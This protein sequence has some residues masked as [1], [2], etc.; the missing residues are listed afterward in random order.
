MRSMQIIGKHWHVG[1]RAQRGENPWGD[2]QLRLEGGAIPR[3]QGK[4]LKKVGAAF[5]VSTQA[6]V[7][8]VS[9]LKC[10]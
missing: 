8:I 10:R 4:N 1:G 3:L 2:E 5:K 9:T 6:L 7:W